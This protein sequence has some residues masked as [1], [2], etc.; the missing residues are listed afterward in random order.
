MVEISDTLWENEIHRADSPSNE[1]SKKYNVLQGS[2]S[3]ISGEEQPENLGGNGQNRE[4]LC[5]AN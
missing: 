2:F 3:V 4:I 5:Y 1:D